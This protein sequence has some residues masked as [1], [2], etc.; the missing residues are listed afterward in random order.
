MELLE[1]STNSGFEVEKEI[2]DD[3]IL[4]MSKCGGHT[5]CQSPMTGNKKTVSCKIEGLPLSFHVATD[6]QKLIKVLGQVVEK[7]E[8]I[9]DEI[10]R[11]K[12]LKEEESFILRFGC[13]YLR[14]LFKRVFPGYNVRIDEIGVEPPINLSKERHKERLEINQRY[15][16]LKKDF[17]DWYVKEFRRL[18]TL[19]PNIQL[20]PE[21]SA[22]EI[23]EYLR[24]IGVKRVEHFL[25][26]SDLFS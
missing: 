3:A 10:V 12:K 26:A 23:K 14:K 24:K 17:L 16:E 21:A 11:Y 6:D 22:L 8:M 9:K 4:I 19:I 2:I 25:P 13:E 18:E 15:K 20:K 1:K 7:T 5:I